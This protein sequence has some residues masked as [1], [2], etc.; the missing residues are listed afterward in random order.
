MHRISDRKMGGS[1]QRSLRI[2]RRLCGEE[3]FHNVLLVTSMWDLVDID[4][5]AAREQ[6]LAASDQFFRTMLDRGARLLRYDH[7]V[8]SSHHI[9]RQLLRN[10]PEPLRIQRELV[11]DKKAIVDTDAGREVTLGRDELIKRHAIEMEELRCA[12]AQALKDRDIWAARELEEIRCEL[13]VKIQ[14]VEEG[15]RRMADHY[16]AERRKALD[17]LW[18]LTTALRDEE[19]DKQ[20]AER[21]ARAL[22]QSL[23]KGSSNAEQSEQ[24]GNRGRSEGHQG[25]CA[26]VI[27]GA[28]RLLDLIFTIFG[29]FTHC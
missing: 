11:D 14:R 19:Y 13:S 12:L 27:I 18:R 23:E 2:F 26:M 28:F 3:A 1:S 21:E 5:A 16:D 25:G 6:E 7:S 15:R 29:D 8:N 9:L 24:P 22:R 17:E 4:S 10:R 20:L